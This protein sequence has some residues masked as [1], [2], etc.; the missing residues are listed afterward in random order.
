MKRYWLIASFMQSKVI[1]LMLL[2]V[3]FSL[4]SVQAVRANESFEVT[5]SFG[6]HQL[7]ESPKR[8]VVTDWTLLEQLLELG[9][10][11]VGAP[12]LALY[13]KF[14]QQ[15][16]LPQSI[17]DIG[18]RRSPKLST[19]R[20]LKP[21][22]IIIGTDQKKLARPFSRIAPV[23]Y[24][25]SFSDKYRTNG[26]KS[27]ERYLQ[28]SELF[29]KRQFAKSKLAERDAEIESIKRQINQHFNNQPPKVTIARF[30]TLNK[31]LVYGENSIPMHTLKLLGLKTGLP[32]GR[33]KWG[34]KD[35][36]NREL[37]ALPDGIVLYVEPS[38]IVKDLRKSSR[39]QDSLIVRE[40]R[41][42][43]MSPAWSYGGAMSVLYNARAIRD[44]L[45]ENTSPQ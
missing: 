41:L 26:K 36:T 5:D 7:T 25:N 2:A 44:A 27:R 21:D 35:I 11:P 38:D 37:M 3:S 43:A 19:I 30:S 22:V 24:Y 28:I 10:E 33:S 20:S 4:Y 18:L 13:R 8:I 39:W 12:E 9:V 45:L 14:V 34:E 6:K 17:I 16:A 40:N 15:P 1:A 32:I 29:Q 23:M 31:S 42:F